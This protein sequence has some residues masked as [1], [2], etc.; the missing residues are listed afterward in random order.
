M[1]SKESMS[2]PKKREAEDDVPSSKKAKKKRK[3]NSQEDESLNTE[4]GI[5]TLFAR[6]DSQLLADHLAQK[7]TRFGTD[8]SPVELEDLTISGK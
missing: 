7:A 1:L 6:M 8:L 4:L 3:G 5:N 2:N